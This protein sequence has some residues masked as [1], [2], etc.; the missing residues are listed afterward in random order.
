MAMQVSE[1]SIT[2]IFEEEQNIT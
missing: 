1:T 2:E